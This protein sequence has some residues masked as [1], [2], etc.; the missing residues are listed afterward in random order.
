MCNG[1]IA[2]GAALGVLPTVAAATG[3]QAESIT[4]MQIKESDFFKLSILPI[5]D[6]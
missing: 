5:Y 1:A 6:R 4:I 2:E 3:A